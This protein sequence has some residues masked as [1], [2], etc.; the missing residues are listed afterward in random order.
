MEE[1]SA[2]RK[3]YFVRLIIRC[4]IFAGCV[5]MYL[6]R[7]DV[8]AVL[9]GLNFFKGVSP[10]HILWVIWV[11]DMFLQIVPIKNKVP[12][13][14]KALCKP[15]QTD[16]GEDQLRGTEKLHSIHHEGCL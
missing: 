3:I 14:P 9:D 7:R 13:V 15:V 4:L 12:L 8:F 1:M 16:P 11:I 2:T 5:F 6:L 10:L